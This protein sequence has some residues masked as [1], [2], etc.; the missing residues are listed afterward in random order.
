MLFAICSLLSFRFHLS[1]ADIFGW[2]PR[3]W[4][5]VCVCGYSS[6]CV[7]V[8]VSECLLVFIALS[9]QFEIWAAKTGSD[10]DVL[11]NCC[12]LI[13]FYIVWGTDR[14]DFPTHSNTHTHPYTHRLT[15]DLRVNLTSNWIFLKPPDWWPES[16]SISPFFL[17]VLLS[18]FLFVARRAWEIS[19]YNN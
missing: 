17:S 1:G 3:L 19:N 5:C 12:E 7:C 8:R 2:V 11:P 15:H 13:F 14:Q 10:K 18:F 9:K 4:V 6:V 16:K